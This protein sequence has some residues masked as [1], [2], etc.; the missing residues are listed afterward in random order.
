MNESCLIAVMMPMGKITPGVIS[1][2]MI[3]VIDIMSN[4]NI[5]YPDHHKPTDT[6]DKLSVRTLQ[7]VGDVATALVVAPAASPRRRPAWSGWR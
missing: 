2:L 3:D 6:M 1:L 5:R 7:A 4:G